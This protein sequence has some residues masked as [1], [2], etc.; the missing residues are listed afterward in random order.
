METIEI[1]PAQTTADDKRKAELAENLR[2]A[3][4]ANKKTQA[5]IAELKTFEGK[6]FRRKD[7][8]NPNQTIKIVRYEGIGTLQGGILAH[9]FRVE[10]KNPGAIWTPPATQFL[11]E[12]EEIQQSETVKSKEII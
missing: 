3:E 6:T 12:H 4:E 9:L 8:V 10:S 1:K 11:D 5:R 7:G 2:L